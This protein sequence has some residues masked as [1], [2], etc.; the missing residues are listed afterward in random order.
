[1]DA[2]RRFLRPYEPGELDRKYLNNLQEQ[3]LQQRIIRQPID[4][5]RAVDY[6]IL[7]EVYRTRSDI[8]SRIKS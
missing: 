4:L 3:L 8:F 6:Y 7:T 5:E 2:Q 1:M